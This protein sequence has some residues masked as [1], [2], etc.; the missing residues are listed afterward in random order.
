[1]V[2]NEIPLWQ[3]SDFNMG[4][5]E[6]NPKPGKPWLYFW[7][8]NNYWFTNFRAYQEGAFS[9]SYQLT[10]VADTTNSYAARY[11]WGERNAF[12]TRT[13]P[14]GKNEFS[15]P[16]LETLRIDAPANAMLINTRPSFSKK[17]AILLHFRET[18]GLSADVKLSSVIPGRLAKQMTEVNAPG[19]RSGQTVTSIS[20]KPYEVKFIELEF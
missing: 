16:L 10:S 5:F 4:K 12:L 7:V 17:G 20:L 18:E 11:A 8:M 3:F 14:A 6:R 15:E 2:S 9:W 19:T 13:F 1:V